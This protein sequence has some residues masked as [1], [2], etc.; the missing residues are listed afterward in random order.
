MLNCMNT[1]NGGDLLVDI[2]MYTVAPFRTQ[3]PCYNGEETCLRMQWS[4]LNVAKQLDHYYDD[5]E[6]QVGVISYFFPFF[7]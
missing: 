5:S 4:L 1:V 6:L 3:L 2:E 7:R